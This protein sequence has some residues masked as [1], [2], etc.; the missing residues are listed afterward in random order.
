MRAVTLQDYG[1][2]DQLVLRDIPEPGMMAHNEVRIEVHAA[3]INPF[4]VKLRNGALRRRFPVAAGH[5]IGVDVAGVVVEHGFD[6]SHVNVG[7]RVYALLDPMRSGSYADMVATPSWLV[8]RAPESLSF[9]EAAAVPMAGCTAWV[10]LTEFGALSSGDRLLVTGAAGGVGSFAVQLA[11]LRGAHVTA[12]AA[13]DKHDY[14]RQLG[15][16]EVIDYALLESGRLNK[17]MDLVIDT[18]GGQT[19]FQ[20]RQALASEG[21]LLSVRR[22]DEC[23][24]N[25][26]PT[27]PQVRC[28]VVVFDARPDALEQLGALFESGQL[29]PPTLIIFPLDQVGKAHE[30]METGRACGKIILKVR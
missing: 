26:V 20:C 17:T 30:L 23:A 3:G 12:V 13:P 6:V 28:E 24:E 8:R 22:D 11:K 27:C 19:N 29:R 14:V 21:L 4:D 2:A 7:D 25:S 15:A 9:E 18:K 5:V 16:D 10:A 1:G